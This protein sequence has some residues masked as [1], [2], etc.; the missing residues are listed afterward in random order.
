VDFRIESLEPA[1]AA[2]QRAA[3]AGL[4]RDAVDSGASLGFLPPLSAAEAAAYWD[5]V[6][7]GLRD[8]RRVLLVAR[9]ADDG[10]VGA[11]QLELESRANA[12]HRAEVTKLMVHRSARR[13]GLG[14]ALMLACEAEARR[15]GR[16]ALHLDTRQ[17]DPSEALYRALGWQFA[18]AIPRWAKSADGTFHTTVLYCRFLDGR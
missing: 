3:L 4:L 9:D 7:A 10:I 14:R 11:V 17:G 8:G 1:D 5:T 15:R 16:T 13:R 6:V 2:R 18:G 12:A